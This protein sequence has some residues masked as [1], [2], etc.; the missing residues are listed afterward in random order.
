MADAVDQTNNQ[1]KLPTSGLAIAGL[2]LGIVAIVISWVPIINNFAFF[3]ALIGL[4]FAIIG[5]VGALRGKK[6]GKGMAIA[7]VVVNVVSIAV[8]LGTQSLY[9]AAIDQAVDDATVSTSDVTVETSDSTDAAATD[10]TATDAAA[11]SGVTAA[12]ADKYT[13][14]DEA[15]SG[16]EYTVKVSGTFTNNTDSELSYVQVSYRLLDADGAQID[17]AFANTSNLPAG[18]TWKFEAVGITSV[19]EVATFELADVTGF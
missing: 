16:D 1:Q 6:G 18:G 4:I 12:D 3:F 7:A 10:A 9:S 11:T 19:D 15:L 14:A 5:L 17:T 2:V 8:V 13:I